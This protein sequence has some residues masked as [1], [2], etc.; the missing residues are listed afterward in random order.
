MGNPFRG[1]GAPLDIQYTLHICL[2]CGSW[3]NK[4]GF[5]DLTR[6]NKIKTTDKRYCDDCR[7]V[8]MRK[9]MDDANKK[10]F[11]RKA[12]ANEKN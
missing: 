7:T 9:A 2:H 5:V 1:G 6:K 11:K 12:K 3:I 8:G 10:L 4:R